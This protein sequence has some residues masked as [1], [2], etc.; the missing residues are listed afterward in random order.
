MYY[1]SKRKFIKFTAFLLFILLSFYTYFSNLNHDSEKLPSNLD[2]KEEVISTPVIAVPT[3]KDVLSMGLFTIIRVVDGDTV[4]VS[5]NLS[6]KKVRLIGINAPESVDPRR[7]VECFGKEASDFLRRFLNNKKVSLFTDP[8]QSEYDRY[9]RV[10]AYLFLEDGTNV[11]LTMIREGYAYEYTYDKP[12]Q[13]QLEFK[14]AQQEAEREGKGLWSKDT[15][16][17]NK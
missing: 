10:L 12:Y 1:H 7:K 11:N 9:N 4:V 6:D 8:T 17:G 13:Y 3:A 14:S 2:S 15:C 16:E 5:D